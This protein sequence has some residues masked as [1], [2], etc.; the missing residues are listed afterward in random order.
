MTSCHVLDENNNSDYNN[1]NSN[2]DNNNYNYNND[3]KKNGTNEN[4][5]TTDNNQR[6]I[7][8]KINDFIFI[9]YSS[10]HLQEVT[11]GKRQQGGVGRE[12]EEETR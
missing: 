9:Y 7:N 4:N 5:N 10:F 1:N 3:K 6:N 2:N 8:D 12:K 11:Y